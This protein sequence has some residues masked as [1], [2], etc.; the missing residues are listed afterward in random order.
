MDPSLKQDGLTVPG[1][2]RPTSEFTGGQ[3]GT[4]VGAPPLCKYNSRHK[5]CEGLKSSMCRM[6]MSTMHN[7]HWQVVYRTGTA[8]VKLLQKKTNII[9]NVIRCA[10]KSRS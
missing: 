6:L 9:S 2:G 3:Y 5:G 1:N 4:E 7:G 10:P 8:A